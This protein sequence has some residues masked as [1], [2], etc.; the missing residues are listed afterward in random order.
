MK[1]RKR[2]DIDNIQ[3]NVVNNS[4][5]VWMPCNELHFHN[6][7]EKSYHDIRETEGN[8]THTEPLKL[9]MDKLS[10]IKYFSKQINLM[11]NHKQKIIID[12][13]LYGYKQ[14]YNC[15]LKYIKENH[16]KKEFHLNWMNIRSK[17]MDDKKIIA[18]KYDVKIHDLDYAIKL[19]C[20]NYKS[21]LSNHKAGNITTFRIRYWK[22]NKENK[23]ID[24]EKSNFQSGSIRK[25]VLGKV[26]GYYNGKE[27]DFTTINCDCR[28]QK[29]T[30]TDT[31]TL[32]VP[33]ELEKDEY[34]NRRQYICLD[35]GIRTFMTGITSNRIVEIGKKIQEKVKGYIKRMDKIKR[36]DKIEQDIKKKNEKICRKKIM[37]NVKELHWKTI[38]YLTKWYDNILIGNMS[39][40]GIISNKINQIPK[41]VKRVAIELRFSA[42]REKLKYKCYQRGCNYCMVNE[43]YTSKMCSKCGNMNETL[44][45]SKTYN[46]E[47]CKMTLD[48]DVNGCRG[49][50]MKCVQ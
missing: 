30:L 14:M 13:W 10:E 29:N 2:P 15:T 44:G 36:N 41:I 24:L 17:L 47:K 43:R 32:Y 25:K 11:L 3:K 46:C 49:I 31:Y 12:K 16:N 42:F 20:Q 5:K 38:N 21:A 26:K 37:N 8:K 45:S 18:E 23:V 50:L 7:M 48:R 40:K 33:E 35:P 19:V 6:V 9:K 27:F 28:L 34:E 22:N 39:T 1:K 4:D